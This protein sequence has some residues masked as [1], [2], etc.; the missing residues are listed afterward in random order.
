MLMADDLGDHAPWVVT[1]HRGADSLA[2]NERQALG[3]ETLH[4]DV[5]LANGRPRVQEGCGIVSFVDPELDVSGWVSDFLPADEQF[6]RQAGRLRALSGLQISQMWTVWN[7]EFDEWFADLPVVLRLEHGPQLEVCWKNLDDLSITW[8]T[9]DLT[10]E[11]RAWG[12]WPLEW[13]LAATTGATLEHVA[14]TS[15][16]FVLEDVTDPTDIRATWLTTGLLLATDRGG[17]HIF[18]ALDENGLATEPPPRDADHDWRR[19]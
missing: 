10:V 5:I 16:R 6:D 1:E 13:R 3:F 19:I 9:I 17:L 8:D 15:F 7:L 11:P 14:A 4:D 18:N 12:D 2:G